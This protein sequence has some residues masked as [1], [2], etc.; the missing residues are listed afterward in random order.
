MARLNGIVI[1]TAAIV[2]G[3]FAAASFYFFLDYLQGPDSGNT[4]AWDFGIIFRVVWL[5]FWIRL[6]S[7]EASQNMG[8]A[9]V[10]V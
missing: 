2:G 6:Q 5:V 4:R 9:L 10:T 1:Y 3:L 7:V 8:A